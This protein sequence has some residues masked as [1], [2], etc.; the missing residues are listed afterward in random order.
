MNLA[1]GLQAGDGH[2]YLRGAGA[3]SDADVDAATADADWSAAPLITRTVAGALAWRRSLGDSF[4]ATA[5]A[6]IIVVPVAVV[7]VAVVA[8]I[9]LISIMI[10]VVA[11]VVVRVYA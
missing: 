1:R 8:A 11:V 5:S 2:R 10:V 4:V 9:G 6:V 3:L 7:G